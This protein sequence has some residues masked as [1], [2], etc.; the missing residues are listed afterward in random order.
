MGSTFYSLLY[1]PVFSTNRHRAIIS[2]GSRTSDHEHFGK[3]ARRPSC[4]KGA[5]GGLVCLSL[6]LALAGSAAAQDRT[7]D[8][9]LLLGEARSLINEDKPSAAIEKLQATGQPSNPEVAHLLGVA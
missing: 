5:V 2:H 1:I 9:S 4:P 6:L 3:R 8:L 7:S